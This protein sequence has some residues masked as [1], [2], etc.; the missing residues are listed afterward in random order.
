MDTYG[1]I[2]AEGNKYAVVKAKFYPAQGRV[3][4][5][6]DL[7]CFTSKVRARAYAAARAYWLRKEGVHVVGSAVEGYKFG[8]GETEETMHDHYELLVLPIVG[9]VVHI[10]KMGW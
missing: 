2:Y 1:P 8:Y 3:F 4:I 9:G 10:D 7:G 6:S 5:Y